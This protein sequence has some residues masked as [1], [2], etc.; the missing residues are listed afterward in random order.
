VS[1][2]PPL[3]FESKAGC[4]TVRASGNVF[5]QQKETMFKAIAAAIQEHKPRATLVDLWNIPGPATFMDR[6]E[7]GE[8]AGRYLPNITLAALV[9]EEHT[10][11]KRIGQMVARNRGAYFELFTDPAS[12]EAWLKQYEQAEKPGG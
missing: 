7:L 2:L 6:F 3:Q 5:L 1:D 12:T 11:P 4:L 9:R 10:D 8:L